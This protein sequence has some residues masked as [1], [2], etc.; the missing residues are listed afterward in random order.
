MIQCTPLFTRGKPRLVDRLLR[1][2]AP[3]PVQIYDSW[4]SRHAPS[5]RALDVE[6]PSHQYNP[7]RP[8]F[9]AS[10]SFVWHGVW[11]S[12]F[13]CAAANNRGSASVMAVSAGLL[14]LE[15]WRPCESGRLALKQRPSGT[16]PT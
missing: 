8:G 7:G 16:H 12:G 6:G 1:V 3:A 15:G 10:W 9:G 4:R 11:V 2:S 14:G 13:F 5:F